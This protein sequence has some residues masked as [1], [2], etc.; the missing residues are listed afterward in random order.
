MLQKGFSLVVGTVTLLAGVSSAFAAT[1]DVYSKVTTILI[2]D[3]RYGGCMAALETAP[4]TSGVDCADPWVTFS[5]TGD[6]NSKS[7][8]QTKLSSAQLALV[9][10]KTLYVVVDDTKKHNGFCFA[11]RVDVYR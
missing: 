5:C 2:D 9:T 11:S 10:Q 1:G 3:V 4:S 6:F 8:S 7:Q